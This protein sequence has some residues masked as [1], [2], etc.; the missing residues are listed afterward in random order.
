MLLGYLHRVCRMINMLWNNCRTISRVLLLMK[1]FLQSC[2]HIT[3]HDC[4]VPTSVFCGD[5]QCFA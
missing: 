1:D 5:I 2:H 4:V 3:H